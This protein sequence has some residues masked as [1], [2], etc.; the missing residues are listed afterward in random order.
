MRLNKESSE[1][2]DIEADRLLSMNP[3]ELADFIKGVEDEGELEAF[4]DEVVENDQLIALLSY[5]EKWF[6]NKVRRLIDEKVTAK[7]K[8]L[9]E[10][11]DCLPFDLENRYSEE[12]L[13]Y[14]FSCNGAMQLT[15]GCSKACRTCGFDAVPKVRDEMPFA[16]IE[17]LF[18][19]YGDQIGKSK[20]LLYYA[21]EPS[22]YKRY[23]EVH[24]L[25]VKYGNYYPHITTS[26]A[27]D[28]KWVQ[29]LMANKRAHI[30]LSLAR[31]D[32]RLMQILE[33]IKEPTNKVMVNG[34][35]VELKTSSGRK[36]H[37]AIPQEKHEEGV[38]VTSRHKT[39]SEKCPPSGIGC[40]H[41]PLI[42]PRGIYNVFKTSISEKYPQ[43]QIITPL[44]PLSTKPIKPGQ[45]LASVCASNLFLSGVTGS[46]PYSFIH[47]Y[48]KSGIYRIHFK[49]DVVAEV[50]KILLCLPDDERELN[51]LLQDLKTKALKAPRVYVHDNLDE[52]LSE[53]VTRHSD[54]LMPNEKCWFSSD[55]FDPT[56][57][58]WSCTLKPGDVP[59]IS[60][61]IE[62]Y[63]SYNSTNQTSRLQLYKLKEENRMR[64]PEEEKEYE[65]EAKELIKKAIEKGDIDFHLDEARE[66]D[67]QKLIDKLSNS[68]L[69]DLRVVDTDRTRYKM[70]N[71]GKRKPHKHILW[72]WLFKFE[73]E[74]GEELFTTFHV[75]L[76]P[77]THEVKLEIYMGD[78]CY[79]NRA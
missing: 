1:Q 10:R 36:F 8:D 38:G 39:S 71:D 32:K 9:M 77:N 46:S 23:P 72:Q 4:L 69:S 51:E 27:D 48:N 19:K 60:E 7:R 28:E 22:D 31:E 55:R 14:L 33:D 24:G 40:L 30:R 65:A 3:G 26:E 79:T 64:F 11:T 44:G 12:E 37:E 75:F 63:L 70:D 50:E 74:E 18:K 42:T 43:G 49:D 54:L 2:Y 35:W 78:W 6:P 53:V 57:L 25:A 17:N 34:Q 58:S 62:A 73:D 76:N 52:S 66:I 5:W 59:E 29:F 20:W 21:S 47:A 16:Q 61:P 41:G 15:F 13:H 56:A 45:S 68:D 67:Y